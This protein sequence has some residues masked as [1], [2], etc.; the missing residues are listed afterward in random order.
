MFPELKQKKTGR[1]KHK[2]LPL[3]HTIAHKARSL[4]RAI[5]Q[6]Q[7]KRRW[8]PKLASGAQVEEKAGSQ[9]VFDRI[10]TRV[11]N[12]ESRDDR[13]LQVSQNL[14]S[15]GIRKWEVITGINGKVVLPNI[16]GLIAG[17]IGCELSHIAAISAGVR[18]DLDAIMVCEDDLE[19]TAS[20][21]EIRVVIEEFLAHPLLDVLSLSGRPRG[22]SM[23]VSDN[24]R[25]VFGLVGR[26]CYL[27]KP[28][29]A[30]PLT[31]IFGSG[32][33]K[34]NKGKIRGKG[35]LEWRKC[36]SREYFFS[37]PRKD[38]AQQSAGFSDIE[39][40]FLGPR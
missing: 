21:E 31:Q 33:A 13:L 22:G 32:L 40:K 12:L 9:D 39:E 27:I 30:N 11:I 4:R 16:N 8:D 36:Q 15:V 23:N 17:S 26:G 37:F 25:I 14:K 10:S 7:F 20:S 28:H 1:M 3:A 5:Q 29:M 2:V 19:F 38:L 24:L 6:A 35:D 18:S 34:L